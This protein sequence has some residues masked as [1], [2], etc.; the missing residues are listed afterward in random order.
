MPCTAPGSYALR[1]VTFTAEMVRP[2]AD[3]PLTP[4][5]APVDRFGDTSVPYP[6]LFATQ[7]N[8]HEA[9]RYESSDQPTASGQAQV[10]QH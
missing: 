7:K 3:C 9:C 1:S 6:H 2:Q 5:T 8:A 4:P 10:G